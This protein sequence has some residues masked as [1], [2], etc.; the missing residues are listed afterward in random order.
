MIKDLIN[1]KLSSA[2]GEVGIAEHVK[3]ELEE[4]NAIRRIWLSADQSRC[5]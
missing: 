1:K 4:S 2:L 5:E 3:S